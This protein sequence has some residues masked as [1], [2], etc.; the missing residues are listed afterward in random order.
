VLIKKD[1][2]GMNFDN[3][4]V[5]NGACFTVFRYISLIL[6]SWIEG[7]VVSFAAHNER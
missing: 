6:I 3:S 5:D 1:V 4:M 2:P 7:G